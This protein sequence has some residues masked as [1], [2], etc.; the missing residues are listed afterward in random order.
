MKIRWITSGKL[1]T[2]EIIN[3]HIIEISIYIVTETIIVLRSMTYHTS[4]YIIIQNIT[5]T[6][7]HLTHVDNCKELFFFTCWFRKAEGYIYIRLII[8]HALGNTIGS[9]SKAAIYLRWKF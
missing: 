3:P 6:Y 8:N 9:N 1:Q 7:R 4:F 5:P 2:T